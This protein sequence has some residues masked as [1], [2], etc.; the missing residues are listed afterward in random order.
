M[1]VAQL[2]IDGTEEN[3]PL[4]F[5]EKLEKDRELLLE[6]VNRE[7]APSERRFA[8]EMLVKLKAGD[9]K[10]HTIP[11]FVGTIRGALTEEALQIAFESRRFKKILRAVIDNPREVNDLIAPN[12]GADN[13][14]I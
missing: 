8:V 3:R 6:N 13:V 11:V 5:A 7:N 9:D 4:S 10:V 2:R 14:P 12:I 1:N